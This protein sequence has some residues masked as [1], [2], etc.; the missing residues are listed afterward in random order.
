MSV[1]S[2]GMEPGMIWILNSYANC[3][4]GASFR[5]C[6]SYRAVFPKLRSADPKRSVNSTQGIREQY[7]GDPWIHFY[8]G[9]F[10]FHL[11]FK[12]EYY[13]L[14]QSRNFFNWR[15]LYFVW[16]LEYLAKK[17]PVPTNRATISIRWN[18]SMYCYVCYW[19]IFERYIHKLVLLHFLQ[20]LVNSRC[21][22]H[23]H[24][25]DH[26]FSLFVAT[27]VWVK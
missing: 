13:L 21:G 25:S 8:N 3:K 24:G 17:A 23:H 26:Q 7:P 1:V 6:H 14:K 27:V 10:E 4:Y 12:E 11:L 5:S 20:I 18:H 22:F 15:Y 19:Y 9:Y 2:V 16:P